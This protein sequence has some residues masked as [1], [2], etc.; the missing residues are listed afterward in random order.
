MTDQSLAA[1]VAA[2]E[3]VVC[4]LLRAMDE[5]GIRLDRRPGAQPLS[6]AGANIIAVSQRRLR[7]LSRR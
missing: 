1:R 7:N 6:A 4:D 2:L 3:H 5:N